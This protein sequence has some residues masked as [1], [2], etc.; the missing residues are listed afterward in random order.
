MKGWDLLLLGA[1]GTVGLLIWRTARAANA[2]IDEANQVIYDHVTDPTLT[3]ITGVAGSIGNAIEDLW[4]H[5]QDYRETPPDIAP[6]ALYEFIEKP[7][8]M[9]ITQNLKNAYW[10]N[11]HNPAGA[12]WVPRN[13]DDS[14]AYAYYVAKQIGAPPP[15]A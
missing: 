4:A 1:A 11:T 9:L 14:R 13:Y 15:N 5:V 8:G 7:S 2:R 6:T 12:T 10:V 3:T